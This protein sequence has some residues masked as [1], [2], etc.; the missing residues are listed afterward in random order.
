MYAIRSYYA[1]SSILGGDLVSYTAVSHEQNGKW[2]VFSFNIVDNQTIEIFT[3]SN[4][5]LTPVITSYS[6]HYTKLYDTLAMQL[7]Q[8]YPSNEKL[9]S[10]AIK[11]LIEKGYSGTEESLF[12][13]YNT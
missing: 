13:R 2:L 7:K 5:T 6:I 4:I 12:D 1:V 3:L 10:D 9:R 11:I 8:L